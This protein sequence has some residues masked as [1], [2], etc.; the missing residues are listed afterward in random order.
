MNPNEQRE[1]LSAYDAYI[2]AHKYWWNGR[3]VNQKER[4]FIRETPETMESLIRIHELELELQKNFCNMIQQ[5]LNFYNCVKSFGFTKIVI[6][7]WTEYFIYRE[8]NGELKK[9]NISNE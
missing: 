6:K 2:E 3:D 9:Y 7:K 1:I 5:R 8:E 4:Q